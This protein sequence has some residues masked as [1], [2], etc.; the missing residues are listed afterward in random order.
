MT[1]ASSLRR[2]GRRT[3]RTLGSGAPR[4]A[5]PVDLWMQ[6]LPVDGAGPRRAPERQGEPH[7]PLTPPDGRRDGSSSSGP[8]QNGATTTPTAPGPTWAPI[9][10][11][12][13]L[14]CSSLRAGSRSRSSAASRSARSAEAR[15]CTA[16]DTG[17]SPAASTARCTRR[18]LARAAV[19]TFSSGT[20]RPSL[21][22]RIG[23]TARAEPS[24]AAAAPIRPP[25]R[26][27]SRVSTTKKVDVS[28]AV[29]RAVS[30]T[31][32]RRPRRR[33]RAPLR[34]PG[35]RS[36]WR[37]TGSRR[38]SRCARPPA[39]RP[40]GPRPRCP[41]ARPRGAPTPAGRLP[42][43]A[44][45]GTR[46]GSRPGSAGRWTRSGHAPTAPGPRPPG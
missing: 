41:T 33:R 9:A 6:V 20:T 28:A 16:T 45:H 34:A 43:R 38:R 2:E 30:A 44:P 17:P 29:R 40:A 19:R 8:F 1:S 21:T 37:P 46:R 10:A 27:C 12:S 5:G 23:F 25:R 18:L 36:P 32:A 24:T 31:S 39:W 15:W 26:R 7:V 4:M 42:H 11:P 13:S 22:C 3:E 35:S 14:T